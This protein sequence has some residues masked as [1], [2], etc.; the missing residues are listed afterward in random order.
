[1]CLNELVKIIEIFKAS[2]RAK[3]VRLDKYM[4]TVL[5]T[6]FIRTRY[7]KDKR[8]FGATVQIRNHT[9]IR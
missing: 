6:S 5:I 2:I 7:L 8:H 4:K 9:A 3:L 1:M